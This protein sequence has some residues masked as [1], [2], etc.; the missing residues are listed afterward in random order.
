[1]VK[2]LWEKLQL[3]SRDHQLQKLWE[4]GK[5][6]GVPWEHRAGGGSFLEGPLLWLLFFVPASAFAAFD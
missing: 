4:M 6:D 1:M 3:D 2:S 5:Q